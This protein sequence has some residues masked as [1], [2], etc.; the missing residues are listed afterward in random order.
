M[1]TMQQMVDQRANV[2][3]MFRDVDF[4]INRIVLRESPSLEAY[5]QGED[6]IDID[7]VDNVKFTAENVSWSPQQL[8]TD[9]WDSDVEV[10]HIREPAYLGEDVEADVSYFILASAGV[11]RKMGTE[12]EEDLNN[13][14]T[15]ADWRAFRSAHAGSSDDDDEDDIIHTFSTKDAL[16]NTWNAS[17][18]VERNIVAK[19]QRVYERKVEQF[20]TANSNVLDNFTTCTLLNVT[21]NS[22]DNIDCTPYKGSLITECHQLNEGTP[23]A[24][25]THLPNADVA[26]GDCWRYDPN[27]RAESDFPAMAGNKDLHSSPNTLGVAGKLGIVEEMESDPLS[28]SIVFKEPTDH[29]HQ[30]LLQRDSED[31]TPGWNLNSRETRIEPK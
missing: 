25:L 23:P 17:Y 1:S 30:L 4:A 26:L 11:D 31:T 7:S 15:F 22:I 6:G 13:V 24:T 27:L 21:D 10:V 20:N 14:T 5:L 8:Q 3:E 18:E 2:E 28:G 16:L 29:P 19:A 12:M 9:P